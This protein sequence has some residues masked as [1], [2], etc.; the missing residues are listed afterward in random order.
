VIDT[1]R[2]SQ[3]STRIAS[4]R[5]RRHTDVS[6]AS[7]R[8]S[9]LAAGSGAPLAPRSTRPAAPR[10]CGCS[11]WAGRQTRRFPPAHCS[12]WR[13]C[14]RTARA[15]DGRLACGSWACFAR[16]G[17]G[18]W[19]LCCTRPPCRRGA[20]CQNRGPQCPRGKTSPVSLLWSCRRPHA[21]P[22]DS[23]KGGLGT[24]RMH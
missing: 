20:L 10:C 17:C 19:R 5:A 23:S 3:V 16:A 1:I 18:G 7:R 6:S 8:A 13:R 22:M 15:R 9:G 2:A 21:G 24:K 11:V 12:T 4:E 14:A